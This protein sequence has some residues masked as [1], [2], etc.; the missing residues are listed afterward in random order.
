[1]MR[2]TAVLAA[3]GLA[4]CGRAAVV[5]SPA[6]PPVPSPALPPPILVQATATVKDL[7]G[8][9][10]GNVSFADTPAGLLVIGSV[11]GLGIGAHGVHLHAVGRCEAPFAS[12]GPH[13]NPSAAK[14]GFKNPAGHH[15]GDL[16]NVV[17]PPAGAYAFQFIVAG[18]TLTG[19]DGL[20]DADGA[21]I[22]FHSGADDYVTDP[23][24]GSG[25]RLACGVITLTK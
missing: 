22:V 5:S 8:A 1:M 2:L 17:T 12:A 7:A 6:L 23:S 11:S 21:S 9:T 15:A 14:H 13:F 10:T 20:M 3:F 24:G 18:V 25:G 16:P 4:A 19:K